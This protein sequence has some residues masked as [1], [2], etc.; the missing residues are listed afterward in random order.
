[1]S[2]SYVQLMVYLIGMQGQNLCTMTHH[3]QLRRVN[4]ISIQI[5]LYM[6]FLSAEREVAEVAKFLANLAK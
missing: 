3:S 6:T 5:E 1:M 2:T 4:K